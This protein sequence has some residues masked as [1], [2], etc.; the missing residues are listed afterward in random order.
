[1]RRAGWGPPG[2]ASHG[3][4]DDAG[5]L[6]G[7][8]DRAGGARSPRRSGGSGAP[9]RAGRAGPRARASG[10][11]FTRS[12]AL[13]P[14]S[15]SPGPSACRA[16][17]PAEREPRSASSSCIDDTP[18]SNST[19]STGSPA[20]ATSSS[21]KSRATDADAVAERR[22]A[23]G[24]AATRAAGSRS[25]PTTAPRRPRAGP[26]RGRRHRPSRRPPA[27]RPAEER[28]RPRP[29]MTGACGPSVTRPARRRTR[30]AIEATQR[31]HD[32]PDQGQALPHLAPAPSFSSVASHDLPG[33]SVP[34]WY[35]PAKAA[36]YRS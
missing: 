2:R 22:E 27:R 31:Q 15:P 34:A 16:G 32:H 11:W 20:T 6:V 21:E 12:A 14:S 3:A 19:P 35:A 5:Q 23:L 10:R 17:R 7:R 4:H 18:R 25:M 8:G 30:S 28:S 13:G 9:R 1:M 26:R 33:A 36:S 29:T 24:G